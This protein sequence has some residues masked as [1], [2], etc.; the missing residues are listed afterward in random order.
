MDVYPHPM[1]NP[2]TKLDWE[3]LDRLAGT[4]IDRQTVKNILT[5]LGIVILKESS[6][7]L[8]LEIPPFKADVLREPDVIEEILRIYSYDRI[9]FSPEIRSSVSFVEKPDRE[10][11]QHVISDFLT[12]NGFFEIMNNSITRSAYY[13][14]SSIFRKEDLVMILNPLSADLDAMRQT[15]LFG[16]LETIAYNQNR[17]ISDVRFYEFG[18][19]YSRNG[20]SGD[21]RLSSIREEKHLA[22]FIS[23]MM[24][25]EL[26]NTRRQEAD[27]YDL[28][29]FV[30]AI[31][32]RLG[33]SE[34]IL[35]Q[36]GISDEIFKAGLSVSSGGV[37]IVRIGLLSEE[38][39]KTF[40]CRQ[41][42]FYA[43]FNWDRFL[44]ILPTRD[45]QYH[46]VPKFP[47]VRR[48]L[49]LLLDRAVSF[50][51]IEAL[52]KETERQLLKKVTLFD[53]YEGEKIGQDKKSY[54][55]SFTLLDENKTLKDEEIDRVMNRLMKAFREKLNAEIR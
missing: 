2:V 17:K 25:K 14:E 38:L 20:I 42:V 1:Q 4:V 43:D 52:A 40:D 49:A 27:F 48:D 28:K 11:V 13:G 10:Q 31:F 5:S 36:E 22:L 54:A 29:G 6:A 16:G 19:I 45:V 32:S 26:W 39:L 55:L 37:E 9:G 30:Q 35:T 18:N 41:K 53:V 50:S 24:Q 47:E 3:G 8:S 7:G 23:G 33:I 12:S 21:K 51:E 15:L 46:P 34:K 44:A